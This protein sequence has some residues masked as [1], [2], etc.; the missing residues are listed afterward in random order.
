M[1]TLLEISSTWYL[2]L[3]VVKTLV[4]TKLILYGYLLLLR[5]FTILIM[6]ST[7]LPLNDYYYNGK[8]ETLWK[9]IMITF[10]V[11]TST[12]W[13][14]NL[15]RWTNSFIAKEVNCSVFLYFILR[16]CCLFC[17]VFLTRPTCRRKKI[18]LAMLRAN[19]SWKIME[20]KVVVSGLQRNRE[21]NSLCGSSCLKATVKQL[22]MESEKRP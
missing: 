18:G 8:N 21:E 17:L 13:D 6:T 1:W 22:N 5:N 11:V 9:E 15:V 3:E 7:G 4:Q 19:D 12:P 16:R 10:M 14:K 20:L 2:H